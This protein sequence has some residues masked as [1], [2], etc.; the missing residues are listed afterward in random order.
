MAAIRGFSVLSLYS[1]GAGTGNHDWEAALLD[2]QSQ[3][4]RG[5]LFNIML[6]SI[7]Y[8]FSLILF[9]CSFLRIGHSSFF[10]S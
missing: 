3:N 7:E 1:P 4:R 10:F 9:L 6:S 5:F 8:V 2:L